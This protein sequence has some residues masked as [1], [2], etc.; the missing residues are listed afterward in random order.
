MIGGDLW[1]FDAGEGTV[2]QTT[3]ARSCVDVKK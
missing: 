2:R 3:F 1:M